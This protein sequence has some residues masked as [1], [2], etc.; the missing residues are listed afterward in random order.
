MQKDATILNTNTC[1]ENEEE[2]EKEGSREAGRRLE[3]E[4]PRGGVAESVAYAK[5]SW[6]VDRGWTMDYI[7]GEKERGDGVEDWED[8]WCQRYFH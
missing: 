7:D 5:L 4:D 2:R 3:L 1:P 6:K 8:L